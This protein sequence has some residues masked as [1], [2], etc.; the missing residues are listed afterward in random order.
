MNGDWDTLVWFVGWLLRMGAMVLVGV[1][2]VL[3]VVDGSRQVHQWITGGQGR[4]T[5]DQLRSAGWT[6][7]CRWQPW[8]M[9]AWRVEAHRPLHPR[10]WPPPPDAPRDN[11]TGGYLV[12]MHS[13]HYDKGWAMLAI[14]LENIDAGHW[15]GRTT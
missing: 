13:G 15:P 1:L 9:Y 8:S 11:V 6:V 10:E 3:F 12:R 14:A 7:R 4:R 2:V 5:R